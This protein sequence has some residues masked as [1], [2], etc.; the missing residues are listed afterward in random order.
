MCN[1]LTRPAVQKCIW[2]ALKDE[3]KTSVDDGTSL[4]EQSGLGADDEEIRTNMYDVVNNAVEAEGCR[5]TAFGAHDLV[6]CTTVG[7]IVTGV[8]NDILSH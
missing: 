2:K 6:G 8:L 4:R 5:L 3:Y 1:L 7:D